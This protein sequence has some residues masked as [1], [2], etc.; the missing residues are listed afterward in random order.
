MVKKTI[1]VYGKKIK[2]TTYKQRYK[3]TVKQRY[4]K[5]VKQRY[6]KTRKDGVKQRYWKK[7]E[8]RYWKKVKRSYWKKVT[9]KQEVGKDVRFDIEGKPRDIFDAV[10]IIK[11]ESLVPKKRFES[12][13][14]P[15]GFKDWSYEKQLEY[16]EEHGEVGEWSEE[17][18]DT[19]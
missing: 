1:S 11:E 14:L 17:V 6:W 5:K 12:I 13:E 10:A 2:K 9:R 16:L 7:T 19:W 4:R 3:K 18:G 8:R 15:E